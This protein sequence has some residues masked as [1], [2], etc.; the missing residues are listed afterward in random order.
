V[1]NHNTNLTKPAGRGDGTSEQR[2]ARSLRVVRSG[3]TPADKSS[4]TAFRWRVPVRSLIRASSLQ[5]RVEQQCDR[6]TRSVAGTRLSD[7]EQ[8][9]ESPELSTRLVSVYRSSASADRSPQEVPSIDRGLT[10]LRRPF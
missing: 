10:R 9:R 2:H 6:V 7:A 5:G 1:A 4:S 3:L 8:A